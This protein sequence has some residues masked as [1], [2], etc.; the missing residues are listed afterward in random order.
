MDS[1][2]ELVDIDP[3]LEGGQSVSK[4]EHIDVDFIKKEENDEEYLIAPGTAQ[5]LKVDKNSVKEEF[6]E[7]SAN[8]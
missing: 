5:V 4:I 6:F 3:L 1:K 2:G 7:D 8:V